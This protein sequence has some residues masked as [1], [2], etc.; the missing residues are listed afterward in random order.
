MET[1][2]GAISG[3]SKKIHEEDFALVPATNDGDTIG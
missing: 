1:G 3:R 2:F